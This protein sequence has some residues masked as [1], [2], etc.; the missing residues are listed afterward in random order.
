M[1]KH[2]LLNTRM[3][4]NEGSIEAHLSLE[5]EHRFWLALKAPTTTQL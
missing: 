5:V 1:S 3:G 4:V 2:F